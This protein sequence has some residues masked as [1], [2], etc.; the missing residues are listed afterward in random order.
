MADQKEKKL[1]IHQRINAVMA[2]ISYIQKG[3]KMVNNQY[4]FISHDQVSAALHPL[5]VKHGINIVPTIVEHS[6]EWREYKDKYDNTK[7][8]GFTEVTADVAFQNIDVLAETVI[9]RQ[10]GYGIDEQD[11]GIGKAVSYA[12][13]Y[14]MLKVFC[15]ET[16]DDPEQDNLDRGGDQPLTDEDKK[17]QDLNVEEIKSLVAEITTPDFEANFKEKFLKVEDYSQLN[18]AQFK[19]AKH[20]LQSRIDKQNK[21][22]ADMDAADKGG[23]VK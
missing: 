21:E 2:D 12:C 7:F 19:K 14:A 4:R 16:G 5:L 8:R 23:E 20:A 15:L 10:V 11:K 1:N 13:K 3:D 18:E 9:S 6:I 17:E 22:A